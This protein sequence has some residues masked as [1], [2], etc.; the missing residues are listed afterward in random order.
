MQ[1]RSAIRED[2]IE[3]PQHCKVGLAHGP[4]IA[5]LETYPKWYQH[6]NGL[7]VALFSLQLYSQYLRY[8]THLDVYQLIATF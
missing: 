8:E 1:A 5:L 6:K 2:S 7:S 3:T 4:T